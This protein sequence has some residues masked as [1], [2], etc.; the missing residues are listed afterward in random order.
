[1][2]FAEAQHGRAQTCHGTLPAAPVTGSTPLACPCGKHSSALK[3]P[4][5]PF[6]VSMPPRRQLRPTPSS[7][8]E[9]HAFQKM[10]MRKLDDLA[11]TCQSKRESMLAL[12]QEYQRSKQHNIEGVLDDIGKVLSAVDELTD[13]ELSSKVEA[14]LPVFMGKKTLGLRPTCVMSWSY[15]DDSMWRGP[16]ENR[17]LLRLARAIVSSGFLPSS[18]ISSRTLEVS[19]GDSKHTAF[20]LQFGD[21]SARGVSACLVWLLLLENLQDIP[22]GDAGV[23]QMVN[24][25]LAINT[26]FEEV[27]KGDSKSMLVTQAARQN[28]AAQ[29]QPVNTFQWLSMAR[30]FSGLHIGESN[31]GNT[32]LEQTLMEVVTAYNAHPEV[33][34]ASVEVVP[35]SK[36]RRASRSKKL[37]A[38]LEDVDRDHGLQIGK[39]RILAMKYFV[40]GSTEVTW[41]LIASHIV[42]SGDYRTSVLTDD[43]LGCKW[44]YVS[45]LLPK[46]FAPTPFEEAQCNAVS[47]A[48]LALIP[49]STARKR[50][51]YNTPLTQE[52]HDLLFRKM[53]FTFEADTALISSDE[54]KVR[55]R[56]KTE[57]WLQARCIVQHWVLTMEEVARK[58]L[59]YE[60]FDTLRKLVLETD[61]LDSAVYGVIQR[62]PAWFHM[63]MLP[64]LVTSALPER[65]VAEA[66]A[67]SKR[68][69]ADESNYEAFEEELKCDWGVMALAQR[70][71]QG[72][73]E[74]FAYKANQ[75]RREQSNTA[76]VLVRRFTERNFPTVEVSRWSQLPNQVG[77]LA[78]RADLKPTDGKLL[79][80]ILM[81]FNTPGARDVMTRQAAID[82][83]A[84]CSKGREDSTVLVAWM[85]TTA[86]EGSSTTAW[87]DEVDLVKLL[88]KAGFSSQERVSMH[89]EFPERIR[90]RTRALPAWTQLRLCTNPGKEGKDNFWVCNSELFRTLVVREQPTLPDPEEMLDVTVMDADRD[91]NTSER[92]PDV[93]AKCAQRGPQCNLAVLRALLTQTQYTIAGS[94]W[95]SKEDTLLVL[96]AHPYV[97][98]R[99]LAS[100]E[101]LRKPSELP[102]KICHAVCAVSSTSFAKHAAFATQRLGVKLSKQWLEKT[103]ALYEEVKD[104]S[105]KLVEQQVSPSETVPEP[106]EDD[107]R[108]Y[109]GA[110]MAFQGVSSL[111]FKVCAVLNGKI[112]I[113]PEKLAWATVASPEVIAKVEDLKEMH[114]NLYENALSAVGR[115]RTTPG[116]AE[117]EA[118][119]KDCEVLVDGREADASESK[120]CAELTEW[121]S[122]EALKASVIITAEC[123]ASGKRS[124]T[125]LRDDAAGAAYAVCKTETVTIEKGTNLGGVGGGSIVDL[126][127]E[128][129]SAV[130]WELPEGDAT[131]VQLQLK[132]G[133]DAE[134]NRKFTS[135]TLYSILRDLESKATSPIKITSFG[136]ATGKVEHGRH[137]YSFST[138]P[139]A[140]NHRKLEYRLAPPPAGS[141]KAKVVHGNFFSSFAKRSGLGKGVLGLTWRC[142]YDAVG[143]TLKPRKV[144]VYATQR[145]V[146]QKGKPVKILWTKG[147]KP[148]TTGKER[149]EKA[150]KRTE[151]V[152]AD[153]EEEE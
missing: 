147:S 129:N 114:S 128:V 16:P 149:A 69:L 127:E 63:R 3:L 67:I 91:L 21:G 46:E 122:L 83:M 25:L 56:P 153:I 41:D 97:G 90:K 142:L 126:N 135:G 8:E 136:E 121:E 26:M 61:Q 124:V 108:V 17:R 78:Q 151:P 14:S 77:L 92:S 4:P 48:A 6:A 58:E 52:Q 1:M 138:P 130:S 104:K 15:D 68:K 81:D 31:V 36:R 82:T 94:K 132:K 40:N 115:L 145:F 28:Q 76:E 9:L 34:A 107:M 137:C 24:S 32:Q 55:A 143:D 66:A 54:G 102:C 87:D 98:D 57:Q 13:A 19:G 60:D 103:F 117:S 96:D 112:K 23:S 86:K 105:G 53:A 33:E 11:A 51:Q 74:V 20:Q 144:H 134:D 116:K 35:V 39:R 29:V 62:C 84:E 89:L 111:T 120:D 119:G 152:E 49:D 64:D 71:N 72:L 18:V 12:A 100:C 85:P 141:S 59:D 44:L 80:V 139:T 113:L 42:V 95:L 75:H 30:K 70:G 146:L 37:E 45:S 38:V 131:W 79:Q 88:V 110:L 22:K 109:P 93:S 73:Q 5:K 118:E 106:T 43:L 123:K 50:M 125:L 27:G 150:E 101:L 65:D 2:H 47:E 133:D 140:E 7:S 10:L 99:V 148:Q